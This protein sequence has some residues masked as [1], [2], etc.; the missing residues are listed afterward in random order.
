MNYTRN[1][2]ICNDTIS[3]SQK[4]DMNVANKI[5]KICYSCKMKEK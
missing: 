5:N 2:P 4:Y 1:F 3:Y